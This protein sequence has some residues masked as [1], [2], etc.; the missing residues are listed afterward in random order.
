[1]NARAQ[2]AWQAI[3]EGLK[4]TTVE[5]DALSMNLM[6]SAYAAAEEAAED[7]QTRGHLVQ[8]QR[9]L[10][11]NPSLQILREAGATFRGFAD[12][13][14]LTPGARKKLGIDLSSHE[15]ESA[16]FID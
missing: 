16:G 6:C 1:M 10:V 3:A 9:G 7:I 8:G 14:G 4:D 2:A 11:K 12:Q 5:V 13:F 15:D